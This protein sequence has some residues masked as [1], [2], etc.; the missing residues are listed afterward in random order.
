MLA[1]F[2]WAVGLVTVA[3]RVRVWAADGLTVPTVHTPPEYVPWLGVALTRVRP[4]GK[5]SATLTFVASLGPVLLRV[6]VNVIVSPTLG[7]ALLTDLVSAR[8]ACCGVSVA[9][10]PLLPGSGSN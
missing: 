2:V 5:V 3:V 7:L 9:L 8:S 4:A 6:T 10:A 1:V